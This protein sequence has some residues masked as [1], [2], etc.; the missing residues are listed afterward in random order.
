LL[1]SLKLT[2]FIAV[3]GAPGARTIGVRDGAELRQ[4]DRLPDRHYASTIA[5]L[6]ALAVC[7]KPEKLK[8]A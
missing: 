3:L 2:V 7:G 4:I 5:Q 6:A 8:C 1:D